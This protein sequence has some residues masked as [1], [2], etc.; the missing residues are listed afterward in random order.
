MRLEGMGVRLRRRAALFLAFALVLAGFAGAAA[1]VKISL[2][3]R[4][5]FSG[6]TAAAGAASASPLAQTGRG[7]LSAPLPQISVSPAA[8]AAAAPVPYADLVQ[9]ASGKPSNMGKVLPAD[10]YVEIKARRI[11]DAKVVWANFDL[12]RSMG[13]HVPAQ[14]M[15]PEFEKVLLDVFAFQIDDGKA[16][17]GAPAQETKSLYA[18]RYG[19]GGLG[20][21]QGSGRAAISGAFQLKGTA[22]TPLAG[23]LKEAKAVKPLR[24]VFA[25]AVV[26]AWKKIKKC[27]GL[28][29]AVRIVRRAG[30][31]LYDEVAERIEDDN[32]LHGGLPFREAIT[33]A[34]WGEILNH[35]AP[36]GANRTVA[37]ITTGTSRTLIPHVLSDPNALMVRTDPLR[38]AQFIV[39]ENAD[40]SVERERVRKIFPDLLRALRAV[41]KDE[42]SPRGGKR[43]TQAEVLRQGLLAM[44]GRFGRVFG[45][46]YA[47]SFYHG[48]TT[49][50]NIEFDG[51]TLD[52]GS[53]TS[54]DGFTPALWRDDSPNGTPT[55]LKDELIHDFMDNFPGSHW[56]PSLKAEVD[57]VIDDGFQAEL[58]RQFLWLSGLPMEIAGPLSATEEGKRFSWVLQKIARA[59]NT[60]PVQTDFKIPR[61]TGTYDLG[62]FL[63]TIAKADGDAG[64]ALDRDPK[65]K[66]E[67]LE[68]SAKFSVK[69]AQ[70]AAVQGISMDRLSPYRAQAAGLRNKTLTRLF[71]GWGLWTKLY[72]LMLSLLL[73]HNGAVIK[74]FI[75]KNIG[76]SIKT[77]EAV[78]AYCLVLKERALGDTG[79]TLRRVYDAK[80]G[81]NETHLVVPVVKGVANVNGKELKLTELAAKDLKVGGRSRLRYSLHAINENFQKAVFVFDEFDIDASPSIQLA[82]G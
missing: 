59:G 1:P 5:A 66:K 55:A 79:T 27:S 56:T 12:L 10:S 14:G 77:Y 6:A 82:S 11:K 45:A 70:E 13:I 58:D 28:N 47:K 19:G 25:D 2:G 81:K 52:Y 63:R 65:L 46:L 71:R 64:G 20:N 74:K 68:S 8:A 24:A 26:E 49:P 22:R 36:Y 69:L 80:T 9:L 3:V 18:D 72:A 62:E 32:H 73:V 15:T 41:Y 37:L 61:H 40:P 43:L 31:S 54:L 57:K 23:P 33:E 60:K 30:G 53:M 76:D 51:A 29:E 78:P 42:L 67:F 21:A 7:L 38:P 48:A 50:S 39:N 34:I 16:D 35:E 44:S 75:D 4:A 17:P